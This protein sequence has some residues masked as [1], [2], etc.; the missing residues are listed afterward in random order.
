MQ[1]TE[2]KR[3]HIIG[4]GAMGTATADGLLKAGT[5]PQNITIC[6]PR[7]H[8]LTQYTQKGVN[9]SADNTYM[10][11]RADIIVTAVKPW[12]LPQVA[13]QTNPLLTPRHHVGCIVAGIPGRDL[14]AMFANARNL[15]I[16]MPNTAMSLGKSMTFAVPLRGD[17]A[18]LTAVFK[19]SGTVDTIDERLLGA[20]TALAS[21]GIAYALRYV[22]AATQGGVELGFGAQQAQHIVTQTMAGAVALLQQ[23]GAHAETEID[24]VTTPGGLTIRGLN[25]MQD[26]GFAAAVTAGLRASAK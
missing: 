20:A 8:K 5:P 11:D 2:N 3:I 23:P 22:R 26:A 25:A 12:I 21:C 6:T 16:I 13:L 1:D 10:I 7:P 15:A 14:A 19:A 4:G 17:T 9:V 24:K 18:P